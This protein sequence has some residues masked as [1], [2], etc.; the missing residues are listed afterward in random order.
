MKS[1]K[2]NLSNVLANVAPVSLS[3]LVIFPNMKKLY[4]YYFINQAEISHYVRIIFI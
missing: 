4:K 1:F 3:I 2:N